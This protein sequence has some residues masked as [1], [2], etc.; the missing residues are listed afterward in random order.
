MGGAPSNVRRQQREW[1]W[2]IMYDCNYTL[3]S[4]AEGSVVERLETTD[5]S[6][7]IGVEIGRAHV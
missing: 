6:C 1:A 5:E 7:G 4:K 2:G 3:E